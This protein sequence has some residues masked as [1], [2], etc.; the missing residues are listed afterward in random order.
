MTSQKKIRKTY[1]TEFKEEALKL[2]AKVGM[3]QAARELN[4][5]ESQLYAWRSAAQKKRQPQNEKTL[6]PQK[7]PS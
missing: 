6:S 4:I 7:M 1:S 3:A 2:A 5:Y